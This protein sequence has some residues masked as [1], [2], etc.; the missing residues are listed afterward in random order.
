MTGPSRRSRRWERNAEFWTRII[1]ERLDPFRTELTDA[2]VLRAVGPCRDKAI[3]DAGC[4]EGY[5]SRM[6]AGRGALA[7]GVD[8]SMG[9]IEAAADSGG[10]SGFPRFMLAD[11][12]SL[13][14]PSGHF[15]SVV[16]NHSLNELRY[17]Q[18]A[19]SEFAR[20]LKPGGR[21]VIL[22][23]HPCFYGGRD[24]SGRRYDIDVDQYFATRRVEQKFSVSG[25]ISPAPTVIWVRPLESYFALLADAG[26]CVRQ[27]WE[28]RPPRRRLLIDAWWRENFRKPLFL[29]LVAVRLSATAKQG[30]AH[31]VLT[32]STSLDDT[33]RHAGSG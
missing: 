15:D 2:A 28:P 33:R 10:L 1:R 8:R 9:L 22:M 23:L 26:F 11:L 7:V 13:P 20:V 31:T 30:H 12:S 3:L 24:Q 32:K 5:L 27:L 25:L 29:L 18:A 16:C 19:I 14:L 21:L 17:P 4:G 6:L